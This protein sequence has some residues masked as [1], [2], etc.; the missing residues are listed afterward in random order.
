[1]NLKRYLEGNGDRPRLTQQAF[2]DALNRLLRQEDPG[3]AVISQ[4]SVCR[5]RNALCFPSL[6][7]RRAIERLTGGDVRATGSDWR[8]LR[9]GTGK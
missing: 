3:R 9:L 1:M 6:E 5:W 2:A 7:T 8:K 4:A